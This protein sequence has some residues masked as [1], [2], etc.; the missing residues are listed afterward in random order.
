MT[1][2]KIG[3][4]RRPNLEKESDLPTE[5]PPLLCFSHVALLRTPTPANL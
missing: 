1:M 3:I 2:F 5:N 4:G